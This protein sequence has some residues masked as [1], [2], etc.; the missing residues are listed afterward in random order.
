MCV[1]RGQAQHLVTPPEPTALNRCRVLVV[2]FSEPASRTGPT[3]LQ[4]GG[5]TSPWSCCHSDRRGRPLGR[6]RGHAQLVPTVLVPGWEGGV[7][8]SGLPA[9]FANAGAEVGVR[10]LCGGVL[11][12]RVG[13]PCTCVYTGRVC[14]SCVWAP[15]EPRVLCSLPSCL[16]LVTLDPIAS[17]LWALQPSM[18]TACARVPP[19]PQPRGNGN[20]PW[21]P[22]HDGKWA[23]GRGHPKAGTPCKAPPSPGPHPAACSHLRPL[24]P[25]VDTVSSSHCCWGFFFQGVLWSPQTPA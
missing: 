24:A 5:K 20:R 9:G 19:S 8:A 22:L 3:S 2:A 12:R 21:A 1:F 6:P 10:L 18:V 11:G 25:S 7:P 4:S 14:V 17:S 15:S 13:T 23:R 16:P